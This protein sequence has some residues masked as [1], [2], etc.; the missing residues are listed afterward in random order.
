MC[1]IPSP[2]EVMKIYKY[3]YSKQNYDKILQNYNSKKKL[4]IKLSK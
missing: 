3:Y 4:N 2:F 1:G